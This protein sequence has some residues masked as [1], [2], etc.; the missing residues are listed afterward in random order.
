MQPL[1]PDD[2]RPPYLQVAAA[3]AAAIRAGDLTPGEP[4]PAIAEIASRYGVAAGTVKRALAVLRNEGL[5][6]TRHGIGSSV[7]REARSP[8]VPSDLE[9]LRAIVVDLAERVAVVERQ[10]AG[11]SQ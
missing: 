7:R 8:S 3:I 6:V 1:D 2:E 9:G 4:L 10:V 5:I 11:R